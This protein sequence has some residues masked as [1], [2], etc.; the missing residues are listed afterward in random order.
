MANDTRASRQAKDEVN[1][2]PQ[3]RNAGKTSTSSCATTPDSLGLRR[4][5]RLEKQNA[6]TTPVKGKSERVENQRTPTPLR[7]SER[8]KNQSSSS[9]SGTKQSDASL[10]SPGTKK[11]LKKEKSVSQSTLEPEEVVKR[12]KQDKQP[13]RMDKRKM[14]ARSYRAIFNSQ[15]SKVNVPGNSTLLFSVKSY[16][17]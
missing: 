7:R 9:S 2:S 12:E 4:S 3:V 13:V 5:E 17:C 11:K 8:G 1:G 15:K 6:T 16:V 10:S 14:N